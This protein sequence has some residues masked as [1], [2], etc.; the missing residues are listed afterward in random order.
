[1]NLKSKYLNISSI[2]EPIAKSNVPSDFS[3]TNYPNP[4]NPTTKIVFN[5]AKPTHATIKDL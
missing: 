1:M 4:F 5:V 3:I 2:S